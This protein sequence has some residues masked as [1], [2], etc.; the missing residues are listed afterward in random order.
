MNQSKPM[1]RIVTNGGLGA[2]KENKHDQ[3]HN[4][5]VAPTFDDDH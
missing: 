5:K 4:N 3:D 2:L 1:I